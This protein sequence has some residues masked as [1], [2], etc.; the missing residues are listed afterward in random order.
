MHLF[1]FSDTSIYLLQ[2]QVQ[3]GVFL[4][5]KKIQE[6]LD[7]LQSTVMIIYPMNLPPHDPIR[8]ELENC[9]DL[10]G[11]QASLEVSIYYVGSCKYSIS[12]V[13]VE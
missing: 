6:T 4:N 3:A 11:T 2:K 5:Q 8:L 12:K 1:R 13:L 9:E 10:T 7:M